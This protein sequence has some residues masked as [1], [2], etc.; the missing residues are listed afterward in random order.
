[1]LEIS[2]GSGC[3]QEGKEVEEVQGGEDVVEL[4]EVIMSLSKKMKKI[5]ESESERMEVLNEWGS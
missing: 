4:Q 5:K 1:M 2:F 3:L